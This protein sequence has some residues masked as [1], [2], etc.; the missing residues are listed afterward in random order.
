MR[1]RW[2]P[3]SHRRVAGA[4]A[5]CCLW[6]ALAASSGRAAP[7]DE[8]RAPAD[9]APFGGADVSEQAGDEESVCVVQTDDGR[10]RP[11]ADILAAGGAQPELQAPTPA[12]P[13]E[14]ALR[15]RM[16]ALEA[17]AV[18]AVAAEPKTALEAELE[19][20]GFDATL[21]LLAVRI[22]AARAEQRVARLAERGR[23]GR[24]REEAEATLARACSVRDDVE[25]VALHRME[26]CSIRRGNKPMFKHY[27]MTAGG[28]VLLTQ[29]QMMAQ[30]P[31]TDPEGCARI[32]IIDE[33][34][35]TRVRRLH[36]IRHILRTRSF[37]Y[38][39]V[40][41]RRALEEE[42]RGL[43]QALERDAVPVLSA[44][45]TPDPWRR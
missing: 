44:P 16:R 30:V 1:A 25:R 33:A 36:E 32:F 10:W 21:P 22:E 24:E 31:F 40:A 45:R 41:D 42:L 9:S 3:W 26:V 6:C 15:E 2:S 13:E 18:S 12:T 43:E 20:S 7:N 23:A 14:D 37:G 28:P 4:A 5:A 11:C 19:R 29:A 35:V 38:R 8:G 17:Q 34:T 39:Q 27:R